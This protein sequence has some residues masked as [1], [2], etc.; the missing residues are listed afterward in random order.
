MN[1]SEIKKRIKDIDFNALYCSGKDTEAY[2]KRFSG[3]LDSFSEY[4]GGDGDI[5]LFSAPGRTEIGGNH[6]DHQHG[7]VLA[8]SLNLDVI[9]AVRP[10]GTNTVCIKSE[11]FPED[12]VSLDDLEPK[13]AEYGMASGLIRGVLARFAKRF[14]IPYE[15][16]INAIENTVAPK[17]IE[18][19][20][21]AFNLG[22]NL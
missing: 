17:F 22:Y 2:E 10:N 18:L 7:A 12:K 5:S 19:N 20:K 4:F 14:S 11:G 15:T 16:W 6:T 9:A 21:K 3:L 13:K 8:G 1:I